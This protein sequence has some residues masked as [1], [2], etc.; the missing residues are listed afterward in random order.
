MQ[1]RAYLSGIIVMTLVLGAGVVAAVAWT[2][3]ARLGAYG[4]T[5]W[6][7][8]LMGALS[9]AI[10]LALY[11]VKSRAGHFD[12]RRTQ[13]VYAWRQGVLLGGGITVLLAL[14]SLRQLDLRDVVLISILLAL[15]EFYSRTRK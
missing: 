7:I 11:F 8:A 10:S 12:S 6:F 4:V 1:V 13:L 5:A 9:G 15:I 14:S 3:P 2:S